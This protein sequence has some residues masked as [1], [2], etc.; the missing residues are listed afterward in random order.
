MTNDIYKV[1]LRKEKTQFFDFYSKT[2]KGR[3]IINFSIT[4]VGN[5]VFGPLPPPPS[6]GQKVKNM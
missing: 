3:K 6:A 5:Y 4:H 2:N 1:I